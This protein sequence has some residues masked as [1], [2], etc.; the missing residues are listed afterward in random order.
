MVE[1]GHARVVA[2]A[3]SVEECTVRTFQ[4]V[5]VRLG[6][7]VRRGGQHEPREVTAVRRWHRLGWHQHRPDV[8]AAQDIEACGRPVRGSLT[9]HHVVRGD[10]VLPVHATASL[11]R[12]LDL[13]IGALHLRLHIAQLS[14]DGPELA[15]RG[16][17]VC[18]QLCL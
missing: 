4:R 7:H 1:V 13:L 18:A 14:L 2:G 16:V 9:H 11:V 6:R 10:L 15:Q 5:V 8:V 3:E 17:C 12:R